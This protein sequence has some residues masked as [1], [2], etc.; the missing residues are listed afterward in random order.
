[1]SEKSK[2]SEGLAKVLREHR[3]CRAVN[4]GDYECVCGDAVR[5]N[6]MRAM[7]EHQAEKV[8]EYFADL[9]PA[10]VVPI[11]T[12]ESLADTRLGLALASQA[13]KEG[14]SAGIR[15]CNESLEGEPFVKPVSP[16]S[17]PL[18][19]MIKADKES[20][21]HSPCCSSHGVPMTCERYRRTHF[22]EV[23]PCCVPDAE[24]LE[25]EKAA[26]L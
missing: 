19:A 15:A 2:S 3:R 9:A 5:S 11:F 17:A 18:L 16:Y 22:V 12:I 24:R 26:E 13:F 1:M 21:D 7:S 4:F 23:R 20:L 6:S 14:V 25:Q 8:A 10:P